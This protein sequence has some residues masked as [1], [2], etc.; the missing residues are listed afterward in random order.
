MSLSE[1]LKEVEAV[2]IALRL[3]GKRVRI[4]F[5]ESYQREELAPQITFLRDRRE[6]VA[7]FL[8][9]RH[10]IPA[11]PPGV[12]LLRWDLK[13]PP[14]AI[15]TCAVVTDPILFARTTLE[16]LGTSLTQPKR[17]VGWS[18]PQLLD[19]LAQ[20]GVVVALKST[21]TG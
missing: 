19:R 14:V 1:V 6:E 2:G 8:R 21:G 18:T 11:M 4:R 12:S 10:S 3:E 17:W 16:Q 5:P 20:V 9:L 13:Q 7:E 15:E